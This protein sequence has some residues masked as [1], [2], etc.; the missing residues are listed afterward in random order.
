MTTID[1]IQN[2]VIAFLFIGQF[3]LDRR[4]VKVTEVVKVA[5]DQI[6]KIMDIVSKREDKFKGI[7][8]DAFEELTDKLNK[9]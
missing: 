3:F 2:F 6:N 8:K 7:I 4:Q 9:K 1:W 5:A